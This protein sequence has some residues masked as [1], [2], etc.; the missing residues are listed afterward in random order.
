MSDPDPSKA[1]GKSL[2]DLKAVGDAARQVGDQ[3]RQAGSDAVSHAVDIAHD[4]QARVTSLASAVEDQVTSTANT[5]KNSLADRLKDMAQAVHKSGEQLEGHQDWIAHLVEQGADELSSLAT[6]L[7][8]NDLQ[9]LVGSL[10]S[11]AKRQPALFVGASMAAGFALARV[12]RIAVS[13]AAQTTAASPT[14]S[15]TPAVVS[16]PS[17]S[18]A[19][20][21]RQ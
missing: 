21:E 15:E 16:S 20:S 13:G 8:T 1:V 6:T 4:A 5:Q 18:G 2:A 9:S 17:T 19:S 10:G 11:L 3:A 14:G 7:R 12:G